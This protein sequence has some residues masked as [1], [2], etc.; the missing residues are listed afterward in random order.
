MPCPDT[1]DCVVNRGYLVFNGFT[2]TSTA[3]GGHAAARSEGVAYR[4][5]WV[6]L[7]LLL[8]QKTTP[9]TRRAE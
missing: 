7:L 9:P 3:A 1:A 2:P 6:G 4:S 5:T 8:Y